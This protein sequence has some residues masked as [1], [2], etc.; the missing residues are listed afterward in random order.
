MTG[1]RYHLFCRMQTNTRDPWSVRCCGRPM[2]L[3]LCHIFF[4]TFLFFSLSFYTYLGFLVLSPPLLIRWHASDTVLRSRACTDAIFAKVTN[5]FATHTTPKEWLTHHSGPQHFSHTIY[6]N[7]CQHNRRKPLK[8]LSFLH[9]SSNITLRT[10]QHR[11]LHTRI[12]LKVCQHSFVRI[13]WLIRQIWMY[14]LCVWVCVSEWQN[15]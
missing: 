15:T 9:L 8:R 13:T 4:C 2:D 1:Y 5:T 14:E 10:V 7:K 12:S 3:H 6:N 11:D